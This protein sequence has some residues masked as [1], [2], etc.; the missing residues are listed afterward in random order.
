VQKPDAQ[1]ASNRAKNQLSPLEHRFQRIRAKDDGAR[2]TRDS[3]EILKID[4][5]DPRRN[6]IRVDALDD[7][8]VITEHANDCADVADRGRSTSFERGIDRA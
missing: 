2:V 6:P 7:N 3:L 1:Q 4:F 5:C 8:S